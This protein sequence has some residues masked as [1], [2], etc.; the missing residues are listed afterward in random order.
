MRRK[1]VLVILFCFVAIGFMSVCSCSGEFITEE[2][3][4]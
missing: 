1:Y 4:K 3:A 2:Q